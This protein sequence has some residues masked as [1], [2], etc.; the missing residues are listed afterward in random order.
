MCVCEFG[1]SA[2][3]L[4]PAAF[5]S[6]RPPRELRPRWP[7]LCGG[8]KG[9]GCGGGGGAQLLLRGTINIAHR[10]IANWQCERQ[11]RPPGWRWEILERPRWLDEGGPN[12]MNADETQ[13]LHA[14]LLAQQAAGWP[15]G[16][17]EQA[18][19]APV[20]LTRLAGAG[21]HRLHLQ[22]VA[23]R[24]GASERIFSQN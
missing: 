2:A 17:T 14:M 9:G 24:S 11:L 12:E 16:P 7:R 23:S 10:Q 5:G 8:G 22:M 20:N 18:H 4:R 1:S 6:A 13:Q 21:A 3:R 19:L 15:A